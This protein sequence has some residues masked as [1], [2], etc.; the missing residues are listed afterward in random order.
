METTTLRVHKAT[1]I[2]LKKLSAAEHV[3]ITE[4]IEKLVDEHERLFWKGFEDEAKSFLDK[5]ETKAR[6]TFEGA[7]GDGIDR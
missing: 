3:T 5:G 6:K 1:Q 7:L 4:L 2:R